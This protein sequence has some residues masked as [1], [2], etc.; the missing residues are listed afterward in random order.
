MVLKGSSGRVKAGAGASWAK[1]EGAAAAAPAASESFT[2]ERRL[3][4]GVFIVDSLGGLGAGTNGKVEGD[5]GFRD[6]ALVG[7]V[8]G[9]WVSR[10]PA[11]LGECL[12]GILEYSQ[13]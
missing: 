4:S 2:K 11:V 9:A 7:L 8:D 1:A 10:F 12:Q 13:G 5:W 3:R 6:L